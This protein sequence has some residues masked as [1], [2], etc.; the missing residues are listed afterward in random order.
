MVSRRYHARSLVLETVWQVGGARLLVD[1]ALDL[2]DGPLLVRSVRAEG[3]GVD[4]RVSV[5]APAWP[6]TQ[7]SLGIHG[8]ALDVQG[9]ARVAVHAP[10]EWQPAANGATCLF[11]VQPGASAGITLGN[12]NAQPRP[13]G[14][15][16]TLDEW[17]RTIPKLD[18]ATAVAGAGDL[19]ATTAAVL[20]GLRRRNGGIV[21]APTMSLPQWPQSTRTWDYRYCWL[22]DSSLAALAMLRLGLADQAGRLPRSSAAS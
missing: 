20:A 13:P 9:V 21:A 19:L 14:T 5:D 18:A 22:R 17:R 12:A 16:P 3:D 1:D 2:G 7:T 10:S 6:G 4:V 8:S 11:T 15:S